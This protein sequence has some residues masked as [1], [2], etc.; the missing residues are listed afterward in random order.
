MKGQINIKKKDN[1]CFL[2]CHIKHSN[3]LKILS[4][5][6]TKAD[7]NVA[8]DLDYEGI[9]LPVSKKDFRKIEK[10]EYMH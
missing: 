9:K 7:K 8:N 4:E 3:P 5:K 2:W 1:K 10:R 6:I